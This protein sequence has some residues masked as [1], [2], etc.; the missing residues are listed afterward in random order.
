MVH[1]R[2][3]E[4]NWRGDLA[5]IVDPGTEAR[6]RD[7]SVPETAAA[8]RRRRWRSQSGTRNLSGCQAQPDGEGRH[9]GLSD[10]KVIAPFRPPGCKRKCD[11]AIHVRVPVNFSVTVGV[12]GVVGVGAACGVLLSSLQPAEARGEREQQDPGS[13]LRISSP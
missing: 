9:S 7:V 12:V 10:A 3:V 11:S 2:H 6:R 5:C 1:D 8:A 4:L 13:K